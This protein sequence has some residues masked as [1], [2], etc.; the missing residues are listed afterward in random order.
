VKA[1]TEGELVANA[2]RQNITGTR[3]ALELRLRRGNITRR[4]ELLADA[5]LDRASSAQSL[6]LADV[7]TTA[8]AVIVFAGVAGASAWDA[9][10]RKEAV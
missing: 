3:N 7:Y 8:A 6:E 10:E 9:I 1:F 4:D 5:L 2:T